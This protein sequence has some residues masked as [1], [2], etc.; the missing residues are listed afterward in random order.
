MLDIKTLYKLA[1]DLE[2]KGVNHPLLESAMFYTFGFDW[3]KKELYKKFYQY[4]KEAL[5][6]DKECNTWLAK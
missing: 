4:A 6:F 2:L 5:Y 3:E 1:D